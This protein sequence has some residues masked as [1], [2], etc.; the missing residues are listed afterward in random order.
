MW[1]LHSV[2]QWTLIIV[3]MEWSKS[4]NKAFGFLR[5]T[6]QRY[7][8]FWKYLHSWK[9]CPF[10]K[11]IWTSQ[12]ISSGETKS[13][14]LIWIYARY[15]TWILGLEHSVIWS[16]FHYW[17][18]WDLEHYPSIFLLLFVA[19]QFLWFPIQKLF[20]VIFLSSF[21]PQLNTAQSYVP[22]VFIKTHPPFSAKEHRNLKVP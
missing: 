21:L 7:A 10:L 8:Q 20:E 19:I 4:F 6:A 2:V 11:H 16:E 13:I 22:L 18:N 1:C 5:A 14:L 9:L 3:K 15:I 17:P 12:R